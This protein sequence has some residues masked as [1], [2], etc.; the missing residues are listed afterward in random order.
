[1]Q[2]VKA[3]LNDALMQMQTQL[4]DWSV[5]MFGDVKKKIMKLRKEY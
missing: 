1:V 3:Y 4:G 5:K 2:V